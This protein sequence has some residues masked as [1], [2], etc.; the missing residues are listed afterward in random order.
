MLSRYEGK[1]PGRSY[2]LLKKAVR[3]S[4]GAV[5]GI[6]LLAGVSRD[7]RRFSVSPGRRLDTVGSV[8]RG[9]CRV[10]KGFRSRPRS[11][12]EPSRRSGQ[13]TFS[14]GVR[15]L[16]LSLVST[17]GPILGTFNMSGRGGMA[18]RRLRVAR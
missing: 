11:P 16:V 18:M 13:L 9:K 17:R 15:C 1:L 3:N 4:M 6:C 2:N 7:G 8:H 14:P 12:S 5:R 10:V